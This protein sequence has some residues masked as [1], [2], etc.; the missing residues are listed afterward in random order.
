M[1]TL[2][3][4]LP[5]R[6]SP[7]A[8]A[9]LLKASPQPPW[10]APGFLDPTG[11]P[12]APKELLSLAASS[13]PADGPLVVAKKRGEQRQVPPQPVHPRTAE[14]QR[15]AEEKEQEER[16]AKEKK[17]N[18]AE[19]ESEQSEEN[20]KAAADKLAEKKQLEFEKRAEQEQQEQVP[21]SPK[22]AEEKCEE[23]C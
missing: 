10:R 14:E 15:L 11:A 23:A 3:K 7:L 22:S 5:S 6:P 20:R 12:S 18:Q 2:F 17:K 16:A 13:T 19:Q 8:V 9:D 21:G 4:G 1:A